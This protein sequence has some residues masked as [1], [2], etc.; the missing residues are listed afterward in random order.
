[1]KTQ[2]QMLKIKEAIKILMKQK[3]LKYE[4][5]AEEL[6]CSI[7][8]I[9]RI[10]GVEDLS[11]QRLFEICDFL[12]VELSEL[13][14]LSEKNNETKAIEFSSTQIDFL[15]KHP[16]YLPYLA[17]LYGGQTPEEIAQKYQLTRLSTEKY[18]LNLEKIGL[19]KV[20]GKMKVK[21]TYSELPS[22]GNS[23]L[24]VLYYQKIIQN[25]ATYFEKFISEKIFENEQLNQKS[26]EKEI[27]QYSMMTLEISRSSFKDWKKE[28][29]E[30]L[31]K[32]HH[33]AEFE[34]KTRPKE[35]LESLVMNLGISLVNN[36]YPHLHLVEDAM[37]RVTNLK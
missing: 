14:I 26:I 35:Q 10:L 36:D 9:K 19:I 4:D 2:M 37:G 15:V 12:N 3:K 27:G 13:I 7:P 11:L 21:P 5:L 32:L 34:R 28:L 6:E 24:A 23:K 8:T 31:Q 25:S 30:L 17:L 1:M 22:L 16:T 20:T 33:L 18:L 29:D